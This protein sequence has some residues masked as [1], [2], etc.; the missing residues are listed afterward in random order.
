MIDSTKPIN[1]ATPLND[2]SELKLSSNRSKNKSYSLKEVYEVEALN[3]SFIF[4]IH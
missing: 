3:Y 2:I 1:D 4:F